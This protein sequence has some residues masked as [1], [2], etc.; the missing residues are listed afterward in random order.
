MSILHRIGTVT[1]APVL[2]S[3]SEDA[4]KS[5]ESDEESEW[6]KRS[7]IP[8]MRMYADEEEVRIE[9]RKAQVQAQSRRKQDRDTRENREK[10]SGYEDQERRRRRR[11]SSSAHKESPRPHY[12]NKDSNQKKSKAF[13][14]FDENT[15]SRTHDLRSR[16]DKD[17]KS[18]V[19]GGVNVNSTVWA[20][21][22]H[23]QAGDAVEWEQETSASDSDVNDPQ[24]DDRDDRSYADM[25]GSLVQGKKNSSRFEGGDLRSKLNLKKTMRQTPLQ[26]SPL[27]IEI[28][29]DEYYRLIGSD[30][31]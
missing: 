30:H 28:D 22:K 12:R 8:R 23:H 7:K 18:K 5:V 4:A 10:V 13:E 15:T 29:N 6:T 26:K 31:E 1:A 17:G 2:Q 16:L 21:L 25:R 20:R 11:R 24:D 3:D 9:R 14:S 27:R 19:R